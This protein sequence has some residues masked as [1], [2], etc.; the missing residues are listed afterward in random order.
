MQIIAKNLR[1][2]LLL[3]AAL[4]IIVVLRGVVSQARRLVFV[5][6]SLGCAARIGNTLEL[7]ILLIIDAMHNISLHAL[8][9]K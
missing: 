4:N 9:S 7:I 1:Y 2:N 5:R 6:R 3:R 8:K